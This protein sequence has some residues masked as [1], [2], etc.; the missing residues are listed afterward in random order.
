MGG[1]LELPAELDITMEYVLGF[2][3]GLGIFQALFMRDMLGGS[4]P[5]ARWPDPSFPSSLR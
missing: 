5:R 3:I 4:Y 2:G 1:F